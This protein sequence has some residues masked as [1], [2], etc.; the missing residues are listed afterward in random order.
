MEVQDWKGLRGK[1]Y[2]GH[3]TKG[4]TGV[5]RGSP[6]STVIELS[7]AALQPSLC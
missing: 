5:D 2:I 1:G 7:Q 4:E 3:G 6:E